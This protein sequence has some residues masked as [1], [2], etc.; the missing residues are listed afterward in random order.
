M[1]ISS[2]RAPRSERAVA[3]VNGEVDHDALLDMVQRLSF[4]RFRID[5][6][7]IQ[8]ENTNRRDHEPVHF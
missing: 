4:E 8:I 7:T 5:H 3:V 1:K 2:P 6:V